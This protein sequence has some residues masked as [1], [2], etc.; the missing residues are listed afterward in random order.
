[1]LKKR[2]RYATDVEFREK[3]NEQRK[4]KYRV[5]IKCPDCD[6]EMNAGSLRAHVKTNIVRVRNQKLTNT[7]LL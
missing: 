4:V 2:E 1:M 6:T 5:R 7:I 3:S